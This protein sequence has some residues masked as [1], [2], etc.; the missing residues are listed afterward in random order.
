MAKYEP[1]SDLDVQKLINR[2]EAQRLD[3][4]NGYIVLQWFPDVLYLLLIRYKGLNFEAMQKVLETIAKQTG[5][6]K[7]H[8][9]GRKGW[10]RKMKPFGW[11]PIDNEGT[12]EYL[13]K[14]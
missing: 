13:I 9:A 4:G 6:T 2:G 14:E 5:R 11:Y 10:A 1:I 7:L 12:L 3:I 8:G